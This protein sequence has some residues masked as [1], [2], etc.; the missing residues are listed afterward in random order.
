VIIYFSKADPIDLQMFGSDGTFQAGDAFYYN[1]VEFGTN[2]GGMD[3][4]RIF[5]SCGRSVPVCVEQIGELI[6]ALQ[7]CRGIHDSIEQAREDEVTAE[8]HKEFVVVGENDSRWFNVRAAD[9]E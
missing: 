3:E 2:P 8:S 7:H 4:V 1:G 9:E 6:E 5:D